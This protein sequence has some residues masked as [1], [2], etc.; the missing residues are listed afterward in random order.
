MSIILDALK[1]SERERQAGQVPGMSEVVTETVIARPRWIPWLVAILAL[2]NV[3]GIGYW[4]YRDHSSKAP[5][6][7]PMTAVP[8][9]IGAPQ[10]EGATPIPPATAPQVQ[11]PLADMRPPVE[12]VQVIPPSEPVQQRPAIAMPEHLMPPANPARTAPEEE[13]P[14]DAELEAEGVARS[15]ETIPRSAAGSGLPMLHDM[16]E[17]FRSR[18]PSFRITMFAYSENPQERF[19]IVNMKKLIPGDVLPGGV[20]LIEIRAENLVGEL[21]GQK[22]L[23]PRY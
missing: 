14:V 11:A 12:P 9:E 7:P 13:D 19:V 5:I 6:P 22:F 15:D 20:L 23:I 17:S 8:G 3:S 1:K 4:L 2:L 10:K 16:P 18:I 21:D